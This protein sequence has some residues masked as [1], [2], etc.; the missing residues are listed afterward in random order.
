MKV[1][2]EDGGGEIAKMSRHESDAGK[3]G[4]RAL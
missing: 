3:V 1:A 4:L 2:V